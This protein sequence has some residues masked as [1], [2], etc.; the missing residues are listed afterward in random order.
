MQKALEVTDPACRGLCSLE[1][2]ESIQGTWGVRMLQGPLR[3]S[4]GCKRVGE[5]STSQQHKKWRALGEGRQPCS[6]PYMRPAMA[7]AH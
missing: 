5:Q 1:L 6:C 2:Q 4:N 7:T 3:Q